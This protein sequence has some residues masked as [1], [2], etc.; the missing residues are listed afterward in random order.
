MLTAEEARKETLQV[1]VRIAVEKRREQ[2]E[3]DE[4][5]RERLEKLLASEHLPRVRNLI[6]QTVSEGCVYCYYVIPADAEMAHEVAYTLKNKLQ[7]L[8]YQADDRMVTEGAEVCE[9]KEYVVDISWDDKG[10]RT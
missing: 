9:V 8:G 7:G 2:E 1:R 4:K 6:T 10:R 5:K 3:A